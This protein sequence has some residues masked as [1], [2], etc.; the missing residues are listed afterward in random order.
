LAVVAVPLNAQS[1]TS[2]ILS[3]TVRNEMGLP[4]GDARVV[5]RAEGGLERALETAGNGSFE[6]AFVEPGTYGVLVERLGYRPVSVERVSIRPGRDVTVTVQLEP[7]VPPVSGPQVRQFDEGIVGM[8]RPG[9]DWLFSSV[10]LEGLPDESR[11]LAELARFTTISN[12]ELETEGLPG[13]FSGVYVDGVPQFGVAHPAIPL[14]HRRTAA[15]ALLGVDNAELLTN[16]LDVEWSGFS[17]ATMSGYTQRGSRQFNARGLGDWSGSA[18]ASSRHF[19]P[20]DVSHNTLRG[21]VLLT[22]PVI[23][24]TAHFALAVEGRRFETPMPRAWAETPFDDAVVST[25][26]GYGV[27]LSEYVAPRNVATEMITMFGRFDW[28]ISERTAVNVRANAASFATTNPDLGAWSIPNLGSELEAA[29]ISGAA[30]LSSQLTGTVANELRLAFELSRRS[31]ESS[32]LPATVLTEGP[33]AF[34]DDRG[35]PGRF[36]RV[37]F[38]VNDALHARAGR[39]RLKVG[40]SATIASLDYEYAFNRS[41]AFYFGGPNQFATTSGVF[42]QSDGAVPVSR[43]SMPSIGLFLQD[44]W[45]AAPGLDLLFGLRTDIEILPDGEVTP[46][47]T[48][49]ARTGLANDDFTST[50]VKLAPRVGLTWNV[51]EEGSW[52]VNAGLGVYHGTVDP[53]IMAELA[54]RSS[55]DVDREGMNTFGDWPDI[56]NGTLAPA[57]G[58]HVTLLGPDFQAPRSLRAS[59]GVAT[60]LGRATAFHL[61]GV[62]RHTDFLPRRHDLNL[63][64]FPIAQDQ[65]GRPLYGQLVQEGSMIATVPGSNRQFDEFSA[66]SALDPDGFSDYWGVTARIERRFENVNLLASYTYSQTDDNWVGGG[67]AAPDLQLTPFPNDLDGSDWAD[68]RSDFDV[69]HRF[70]LGGS[71]DLGRVRLAGFYRF[72]SGRLFTPGFRDGVDANGDGSARNDPAF[73][74]GTLPGVSDLFAAWDCLQEQNGRFVERNSCRA[75]SVH[76]LDLRFALVPTSKYPVTLVIDALN[77]IDSDIADRDRALY[78]IDPNGSL[79]VDP[80]SG[81]VAVPL[82][83]NPNFGEPVVRR[84]TGRKVRIG[85]RVNYE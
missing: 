78:L 77:L 34:G 18:L 37:S 80:T 14:T 56:P 66:V 49:L 79:T 21:G 33:I 71:V 55:G 32:N 63:S 29:D 46:N 85:V 39:H 51:D 81:D 43:F 19:E 57:V 7:T 74:D 53:A 28:Q 22:G 54:T 20:G 48:L 73:V 82:V 75:P 23:R 27:D 41:G 2:G 10:E 24:D 36:E 72:Q 50:S 62:Y 76:T 6:F 35:L 40:A 61:S 45:R 11:D 31:Y 68:G 59:F 83:A 52:I 84:T 3:G 5:L 69:P 9:S 42:T 17:S 60:A 44:T 30:T 15:F 65:F 13:R 70:I 67:G 16:G 12:D 26:S 4:M 25:A 47:A 64:P 38:H 1:I 8:S 58:E